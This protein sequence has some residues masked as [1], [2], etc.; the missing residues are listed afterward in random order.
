MAETKVERSLNEFGRTLFTFML[1][2]NIRSVS[3]LAKRL[4]DVGY[5]VSRQTVANYVDGVTPVSTPFVRACSR[6]LHL[7][8]GEKREL[9]WAACYGD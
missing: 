4:G 8:K 1:S 5:D 6:A 3:E 9:A 2:R 7:N